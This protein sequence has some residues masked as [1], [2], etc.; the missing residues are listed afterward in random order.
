MWLSFFF[1]GTGNH[2]DRDFP[3]SHSN[4]AALF[5]AHKDDPARGVQPFYYEGAGTPFEFEQ[6]HER[7]LTPVSV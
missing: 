5:Q 7:V 3:Q 1:D 2:K 4:V 6:R